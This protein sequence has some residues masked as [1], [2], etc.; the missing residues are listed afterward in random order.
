[1]SAQ[2]CPGV[3]KLL[4]DTNIWVDYFLAR[5]DDCKAVTRLFYLAQESESLAL[6][7]VSH[8]IKDI[9][10]ILASTMKEYARGQE[11]SLSADAAAAARE[12]AWGCV[13]NMIDRAIVIPVGQS[14]LLQAFTYKS[15]HD[16]FEDDIILGAA[17]RAEVDYIL[18]HDK[19]LARHSPIPC[20]EVAQALELLGE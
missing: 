11:G 2:A 12:V 18:T 7:V 9:A 13:R 8:S 14:E 17:R 15:I 4:V 3:T 1:M 19:L 10:Y 6:Y 20:I 5:S 16:D